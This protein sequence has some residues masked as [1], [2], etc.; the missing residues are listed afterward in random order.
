MKYIIRTV[1]NGQR[2]TLERVQEKK[3]A[4]YEKLLA[5][6]LQ[7]LEHEALLGSLDAMGRRIEERVY[8]IEPASEVS[9][10]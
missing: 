5:S 9:Y 2:I 1:E 3:K 10:V 7:Y 4:A 8:I 6:G